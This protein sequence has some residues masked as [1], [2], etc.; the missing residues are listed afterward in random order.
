M[1]RY[2]RACCVKAAYIFLKKSSFAKDGKWCKANTNF[3]NIIHLLLAN[4]KA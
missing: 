3:I 1:L 2:S 4:V